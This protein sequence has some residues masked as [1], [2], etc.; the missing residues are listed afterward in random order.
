MFCQTDLGDK[1]KVGIE[2]FLRRVIRDYADKQRHDAFHN[3]RVALGAELQLPFALVAHEPHAALAT[4]DKVLLCFEFGGQR[5]LLLAHGDEQLVL[6]H[7]VV[8]LCELL[9]NLVLYFVN[10]HIIHLCYFLQK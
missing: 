9:D 2:D 8:K 1:V 4:V 6:V 10:R 3:Q 7:P 5:F